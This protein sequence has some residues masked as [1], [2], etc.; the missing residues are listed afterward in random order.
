MTPI[1]KTPLDAVFEYVEGEFT[2]ILD[3]PVRL[4][5]ID[6]VALTAWSNTWKSNSDRELLNGSLSWIEK[7]QY[8]DK[9]YPEKRRFDVAV[10]SQDELCGLSLGYLSKDSTYHAIHYL[11]ESL[12]LTQPLKGYILNIILVV[13]MEYAKLMR[14]K[15]LRLIEPNLELIEVYKNLGFKY[16][17]KGFSGKRNY[18]EKE[19]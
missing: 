6:D 17:M 15:Y 4:S 9:Q 12:L 16:K 2:R 7:K 5:R 18:F 8:N 1:Q 19:V 13:G 14:K 10:W 11:E 3:K